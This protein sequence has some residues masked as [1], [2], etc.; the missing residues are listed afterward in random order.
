MISKKNM[1]EAVAAAFDM[2]V[3]SFSASLRLFGVIDQLLARG[4]CPSSRLTRASLLRYLKD[5]NRRNSTTWT[6][7]LFPAEILHAANLSPVPLE[8][9]AGLLSTLGLSRRFLDTAD[10]EGAPATMCSFHRSLMGIAKTRFTSRPR[11]VAATSLLCDG[12]SKTFEY[13][14]K[15]SDAPYLFLDVPF[16]PSDGAVDYVRSQLKELC[17]A[18][19]DISGVK[20]DSARLSEVAENS[21]RAFRLAKV[22]FDLSAVTDKNLFQGHEIAN[23][24]FPMH[25]LLGTRLLPE[26]LT[27]RCDDLRNGTKH[28]RFYNSLTRNKSAK[29]LMWLHIVPQYDN[30]FWG[31]IDDGVRAKIVCDEY[32]APY[33]KEYDSSDPLSSIAQRLISHPSNGP[34]C[35]RVKEIVKTARRFGVDGVVHYSS[36]GCHQAAGNA[37]LLGDALSQEGLKFIN[38]NGDAIDAA[39][40]AIEQNRT[41]LEAFLETLENPAV[42]SP[43]SPS[44]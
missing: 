24:C 44:L 19:G 3:I 8:V 6:S 39:N 41:R 38:I 9:L 28:S 37:G 20:V 32:S 14:A 2:G 25:F 35:R 23:F 12:N 40:S 30:D 43:E 15:A 36:W 18:V 42:K 10:A 22:F 34:L 33:F 5:A 26:L 7:V 27:K 1:A 17:S 29:K 21:N 13:A 31:I 16:E 11:L 4:R